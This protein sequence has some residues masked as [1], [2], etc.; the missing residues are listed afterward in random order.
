MRFR[1]RL[2]IA[3]LLGVALVLFPNSAAFANTQ[4]GSS[5]SYRDWFCSYGQTWITDEWGSPGLQS[6]ATI[7][8]SVGD[9]CDTTNFQTDAGNIAVKQT[10]FSWTPERGTFQCGP[11]GAWQL[12]AW[13]SHDVWT[14]SA[15]SHPCGAGWYTGLGYSAIRWNG[16]WRGVDQNPHWTPWI[17]A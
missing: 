15:F 11:A 4:Q 3:V 9:F 6:V 17:W 8:G 5:F 12:N 13:R 10:L 16:I 1:L 7:D 14:W 2:R